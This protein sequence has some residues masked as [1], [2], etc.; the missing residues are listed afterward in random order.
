MAR[1]RLTVRQ[2]SEVLLIGVVPVSG[3]CGQKM[4]FVLASFTSAQGAAACGD[5]L[6][7][8]PTGGAA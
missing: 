7:S 6:R 3:T 5:F 4:P 1:A 2:S 8:A